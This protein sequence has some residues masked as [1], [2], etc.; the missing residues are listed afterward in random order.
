ISARRPDRAAA[1][2][3]STRRGCAAFSPRCAMRAT[4]S[5]LSSQIE[6]APARSAGEEPRMRWIIG[7][8]LVLSIGNAALAQD[9]PEAMNMRLVGYSDLQARSAYQP[10]IHR[11]GGRWI[12]YIGHHGGIPEAE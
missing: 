7:L 1:I 8:A 11:Q 6:R 4:S 2:T 5:L 3:A 9:K 10:V 12:A